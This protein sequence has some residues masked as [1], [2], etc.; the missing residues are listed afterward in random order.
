MSESA[1]SYVSALLAAVLLL[2]C[3][4]FLIFPVDGPERKIL[5]SLLLALAAYKGFLLLLPIRKG[6]EEKAVEAAHRAGVDPE[7][8][9]FVIQ[10]GL[11]GARALRKSAHELDGEVRAAVE[12]IAGIAEAI[13]AG[14]LNDPADAARCKL[15]LFRYLEATREIVDRYREIGRLRGSPQFKVVLE[16]SGQT[17]CEIEQVLT[18]QYERNLTDEALEL[19]IQLDVLRDMMR[20]D[21]A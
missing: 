9:V 13:V 15:V 3:H 6:L 10:T 4:F 7:E 21:G 14:L 18:K 5:L 1:V 20:Y 8:V 2:V 16:K 12:R 19:D 11:A 17:L